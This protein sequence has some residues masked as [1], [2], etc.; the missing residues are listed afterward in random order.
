MIND[1]YTTGNL[2]DYLH[3]Q[4]YFQLIDIDWSRQTNTS[5]PQQTISATILFVAEKKKKKTPLN[6]CLDS[7]IVTA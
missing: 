4:N 1:D 6:F 7:L 2:F 3:Q 5:I